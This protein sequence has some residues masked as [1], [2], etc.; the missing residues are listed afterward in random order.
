[1]TDK[2]TLGDR[3]EGYTARYLQKHGYVI[4]E[5]NW[6]S[7]YGEIDIIA[8]S[9]EYLLFVEVKTRKADSM[10]PG[11][12][13]VTKQKQQ[14]LRLTAESYLLEYPTEKQP[15]FDV[16]VLT[17]NNDKLLSFTYYKSAF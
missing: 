17:V 16:A 14:K 5:R 1:M 3:G 4:V 12:L 7:R 9:G 8:E 10:V 11:E 6:H 2:R 15:R 13:A